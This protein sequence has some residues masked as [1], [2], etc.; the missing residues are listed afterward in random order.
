VHEPSTSV[1]GAPV[2]LHI[3][4][5]LIV[6]TNSLVCC[7]ICRHQEFYTAARAYIEGTE[8]DICEEMEGLGSIPEI[9]A[10]QVGDVS[11]PEKSMGSGSS[12][13]AGKQSSKLSHQ[14]WDFRKIT[15]TLNSLG[16]R[17]KQAVSQGNRFK[18]DVIASHIQRLGAYK[19]D[20]FLD[21]VVPGAE[22]MVT[23]K[24]G[25]NDL[26]SALNVPSEI[27]AIRCSL[28]R[29]RTGAKS[30]EDIFKAID[31]IGKCQNLEKLTIVGWLE[32]EH[33]ERLCQ[34]VQ[35]SKVGDLEVNMVYHTHTTMTTVC[36]MVES[37][38]NLKHL[39]F[40]I[41]GQ[42]GLSD[43]NS[44]GSML[45]KN[46]T[47]EHLDLGD[48]RIDPTGIEALLQPLTG[49][50][51]QLPVNTSLK[52]ISVPS[53]SEDN[54]GHRVAKAVAAMLTSNKTLTHLNLAG[55]VFSEPS[56]VC[57]VLESLETN[58]TLQTLDLVGCSSSFA[59]EE[60]VFVK[61]LQFA[62]GNPS[63]KSIEL[64]MK[65]LPEG[66]IEAVK[67][68]FAAN[69]IK[70]SGTNVENLREKALHN[71][72]NPQF[73]VE[74]EVPQ[75]ILEYRPSDSLEIGL[76]NL[77]VSAC[78]SKSITRFLGFEIAIKMNQLKL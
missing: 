73:S 50:Q 68:Q 16:N 1:T 78:E 25:A 22:G 26:I 17:L 13:T 35:T 61:M 24:V 8:L 52:H 44:L 41:N 65:N 23:D 72:M 9:N 21:R 20:F 56:D 36:K 53:A 6:I 64:P 34:S 67:A 59:W 32:R 2:S 46:S 55:D 40:T 69:A 42:I 19:L 49:A 58:E 60:D 54:T 10:L 47:L 30:D 57:M 29:L 37:N 28:S 62:Q 31:T 63:L 15:T 45:A 4:S 74:M 77:E 48:S 75:E 12:D 38:R 43:A 18:Q 71:P 66:H 5:K 7:N 70:S 76:D 39:T 27:K 11:K 51:G 33:L 3:I 14:Y